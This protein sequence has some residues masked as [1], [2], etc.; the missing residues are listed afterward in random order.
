[1]I[2]KLTKINLKYGLKRLF[3]QDSSKE[4]ISLILA[5]VIFVLVVS[6]VLDILILLVKYYAI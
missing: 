5:T 3:A 4:E 1:M 6:T 2:H